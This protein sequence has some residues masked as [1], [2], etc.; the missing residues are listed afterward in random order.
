MDL[1][2]GDQLASTIMER[3]DFHSVC[4]IGGH[5]QGL[6]PL[7]LT[8]SFGN[9]IALY[10]RDG[11]SCLVTGDRLGSEVLLHG[12]FNFE[13]TINRPRDDAAIPAVAV[14]YEIEASV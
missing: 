6:F 3:Q 2:V 13:A 4:M 14:S 11:K 1:V 8:H 5:I 12:Q 9:H 10:I 7:L